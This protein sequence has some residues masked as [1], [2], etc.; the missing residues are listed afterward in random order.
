MRLTHHAL[1]PKG[2]S[3]AIQPR[4][5]KDGLLRP[6]AGDRR[7]ATSR[8]A[9]SG[10]PELLGLVLLPW[11]DQPLVL[12][13]ALLIMVASTIAPAWNEQATPVTS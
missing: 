9:Q 13:V 1:R 10:L 2:T 5:N 8:H 3:A 12:G 11:N 6:E 7:V 4:L